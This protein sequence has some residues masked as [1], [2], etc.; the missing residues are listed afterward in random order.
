MRVWEEVSVIYSCCEQEGSQGEEDWLA[1][2]YVFGGN[3]ED[4]ESEDYVCEA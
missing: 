3:G 2:I 1:G 4:E